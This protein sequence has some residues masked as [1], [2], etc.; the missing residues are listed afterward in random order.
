[1]TGSRRESLRHK[2]PDGAKS[3]SEKLGG[4][5]EQGGSRSCL[6]AP[7]EKEPLR[8]RRG[9]SIYGNTGAKPRRGDS[10]PTCTEV[11]PQGLPM[12]ILITPVPT[13]SRYRK[14]GEGSAL[15]VTALLRGRS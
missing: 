11:G 13:L 15:G 3:P 10:K 2:G 7:E 5:A 8:T 6:I 4:A 1:M 12:Q 9:F 14:P